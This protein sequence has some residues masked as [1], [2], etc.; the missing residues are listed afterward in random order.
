MR[1]ASSAANGPYTPPSVAI[2]PTGDT[3]LGKQFH[4]PLFTPV[5]G[6]SL[7][8]RASGPYSRATRK[9]AATTGA[10]LAV[11]ESL[12]S[13][14]RRPSR[15]AIPSKPRREDLEV[16]LDQRASNGVRA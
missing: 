11:G 2:L 9:A 5:A 16:S 14:R 6:L 7:W 13:A 4:L 8:L 10:S 3:S 15:L 12:V 1:C